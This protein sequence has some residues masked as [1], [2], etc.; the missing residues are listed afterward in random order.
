MGGATFVGT[1]QPD[2]DHDERRGGRG[3]PRRGPGLPQRVRDPRYCV[4]GLPAAAAGLGEAVPRRRHAAQES[5][6]CG[7]VEYVEVDVRVGPAGAVHGRQGFVALPR[8][9]LSTG[10]DLPYH[11]DTLDDAYMPSVWEKLQKPMLAFVDEHK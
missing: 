11:R 9:P 7:C 2:G 3:V 8:G 4:S 5:N 6:L 10:R 1:A